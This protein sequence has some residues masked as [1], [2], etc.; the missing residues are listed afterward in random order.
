MLTEGQPATQARDIPIL[1]DNEL[2]LAKMR[3]QLEEIF[4]SLDLVHD[5]ISVC[6]EAARSEGQ[7]EIANVLSLSVCNRLFGQLKSLTSVI[8]RL[9]G[10]TGLSEDQDLEEAVQEMGVK[11]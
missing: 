3:R 11:S 6:S 2:R 4:R 10:S 9:G 8:E 7:P 1:K 5:E